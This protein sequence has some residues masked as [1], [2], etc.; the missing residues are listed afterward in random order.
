MDNVSQEVKKTILLIED[1]PL[2][3]KMYQTKFENE[4]YQVLVATDGEEGLKAVIEGKADLI[5]L[6]LMMPKIS[7]IELLT[8]LQSGKAAKVMP[9]LVL[10]NLTQEEEKSKLMALGVKEYLIKANY[11]P[12]QVVDIIRKYI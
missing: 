3:V 4:G 1:D 8:R 10:T 6:D 11:T 5:I 9:V 12:T 7:G 2:L